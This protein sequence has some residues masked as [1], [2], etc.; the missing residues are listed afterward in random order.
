MDTFVEDIVLRQGTAAALAAYLL[1]LGE[2]AFTT[3]TF[4][5]RIGDGVTLG[6]VN[7]FTASTLASLGAIF[8]LRVPKTATYT[9][10]LADKG[11]FYDATSGT[12]DFALAA[13]ATLGDNWLCVLFNSG[14]G[15]VTI[16]PNGAETIRDSV[17]SATTK[18][19]AQGEGGIIFCNATDFY[20]LRFGGSTAATL[21]ALTIHGADIASAA[22]LN[23]DSATGDLIDVTGTTT[24][25]AITLAEGRTRTVRF[26]GIL[27]LTNGASLVLLT[28]ANITTAAG[29][30]MQVRGY[31]AGVVRCISYHR[32]DGTDV[33]HSVADT[34]VNK[35][36]Q[37]RVN[38]T[39]S[40]ATPAINTD[41][42]DIFTIT[43]LA[44]AITS[45][46]TSLTGTPANGEM[47]M[48][49]IK[50]NGTARAITWGASFASRGATLPTT[51]VISKILYVLLIWNSTASTWDC[52]S[53]AQ[54]A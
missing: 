3:D 42:T 45:M 47:L 37:P 52:I 48:I 2:P 16:N 26:T 25:T 11:K 54:E 23:L 21:D 22:T 12:W 15:V 46:T 24:V 32:A 29:D 13:A 51:T 40:S 14:S 38:T 43:A 33:G 8:N 7:P 4:A 27:T 17:S 39:A 41:T 31:A 28:G 20:L 50:D 6:G 10:L 36:V 53:T 34:L 30:F 44:A 9:A 1:R 19:L 18:T 5:F 35:R 49:R